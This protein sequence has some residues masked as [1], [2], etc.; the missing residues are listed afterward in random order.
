MRCIDALAEKVRRG[1]RLPPGVSAVLTALTP[2]YRFGM[3]RRLSAPRIKLDAYVISIGNLTAGGTGKTPAVIER[4]LAEMGKGRRVAVLTRGY[5]SEHRGRIEAVRTGSKAPPHE[6][7]GDEPELIARKA[8]GAVI[9]KGAAREKGGLLA[10]EEYG[11]DT[12]ILDDG[13]QYVQLARDENI[14]LIDAANPFGSGRILPR[15]ILREPLS[16][17]ARA[18]QIILTRCDQASNLD[19]LLAQLEEL[20]PDLPVRMT[21]HR[22]TGLW[23]VS[24]GEQ[25]PLEMLAGAQV[26]AVCAIANPDAFFKTLASLGA[27]IVAKIR[28]RDHFAWSANAFPSSKL[29][30]TTEKDA[31]RLKATP[32][33]VYA[34]AVELE[35]FSQAGGGTLRT[36]SRSGPAAPGP[37][38]LPL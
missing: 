6:W 22:P 31:V 13:Y 3:R 29:I 20:A 18:T 36:E 25:V 7:L 26:H 24:N 11:C 14:L 8:P 2:F 10:I 21:R 5:A 19:V 9:I 30:V 38:P 37:R 33:N 34:L 1:D 15:G 12:L 28:Y 16:A 23:R 35:D 32:P 4:A 17:I 27:H